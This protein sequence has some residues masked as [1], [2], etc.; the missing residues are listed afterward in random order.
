MYGYDERS[1]EERIFG[2][3]RIHDLEVA[4]GPKYRYFTGDR[5]EIFKHTI[6]ISRFVGEPQEILLKFFYPQSEYILTKPIH[7]SQEVIEQDEESI[8]V[9]LYLRINYELRAL[10][11]SYGNQ[12]EVVKPDDLE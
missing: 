9:K 5:K 1:E 10:I 3:D 12:V 8:T 7:E 4:K 2:L 11:R 6:G